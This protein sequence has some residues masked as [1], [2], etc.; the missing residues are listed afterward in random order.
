MHCHAPRLN[1][2]MIVHAWKSVQVG[3]VNMVLD[4]ETNSNHGLTTRAHLAVTDEG[5][6][7]VSNAPFFSLLPLVTSDSNLLRRDDE[8]ASSSLVQKVT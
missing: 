1:E 6:P 7:P 5:L 3:C 8:G 2:Y 4:K